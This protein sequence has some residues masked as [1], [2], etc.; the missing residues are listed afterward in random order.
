VPLDGLPLAERVLSHVVA[1]AQI[2]ETEV[3][4]LHVVDSP[5]SGAGSHTIHP[6]SWQ[7][8]KA[9]SAYAD[10]QKKADA[11][12]ADLRGKVD[13]VWVKIDQALGRVRQGGSSRNNRVA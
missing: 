11:A 10:I 4:L 1:L 2:F 12:L 13:E 3:T 9:E 8:R 6:L 5:R 7:I